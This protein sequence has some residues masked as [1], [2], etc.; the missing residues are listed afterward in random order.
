MGES[1]DGS[2]DLI[3]EFGAGHD[4]DVPPTKLA[5]EPHV[6]AA[7]TDRERELVF[8]D[9]DDRAADHVTQQHLLD[10]GR[11]QRVGDQDFRV[12]AIADDVDVFTRE[13]LTDRLDPAAA[14]ADAHGDRVDLGVDAADGDLA[15]VTRFAADRVDRDHLLAQ[16]GDLLFEQSLNELWSGAAEDDANTVPGRPDFEHDRPHP[17]VGVQRFAWNLFAAGQDRFDVP[18]VDRGD[19]P[20]G[21]ADNSADDVADLGAVFEQ[22]GVPLGLF[23]LLND[24][25]F[26]G[27]S[28]DPSDLVV[29]ER[30]PFERRRDAAVV[31][32]QLHL[33]VRVFAVLTLGRGLQGR[34]DRR[35]NEVLVDV[36]LAVQ[37]VDVT[38][39]VLGIHDGRFKQKNSP[40]LWGPGHTRE[41]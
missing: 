13:F 12:L 25:L 2:L 29:A 7:A 28:A 8:L 10:L 31:P 27:L 6:L 21:L 4:F 23:H 33:D 38:E 20:V 32:V 26:G 40:N 22:Q 1:A 5:S 11:L 30:F 16:F 19:A 14:I 17:F 39:D 41:P 3:F 18:Q 36:L 35:E 15:A 24:H 34:L 9:E 37:R